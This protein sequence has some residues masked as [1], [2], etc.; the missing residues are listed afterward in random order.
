MAIESYKQGPGSLT[1]GAQDA[2]A[3]ITNCR[4]EAAEQV[5]STDAIPVLSGEELPR[6]DVVSLN[7]TLAGTVIQDIGATDLVAYTWANASDEVAFEFIPSTAEGR[8]VTG[9]VRLV[10]LTVGGDNQVRN[11][12]DFTM[13]I[14]GTPV[15]A[16]AA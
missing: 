9:T 15:L 8:A 13:V 6:Q 2:S 14:V 7:W 3:Q 4:V 10:P 5:T 1:F 16:A 11:T 12:A